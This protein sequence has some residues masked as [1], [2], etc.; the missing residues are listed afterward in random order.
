MPAECG[1]LEPMDKNTFLQLVIAQ[2]NGLHS[3][4]L[5]ELGSD[6]AVSFTLGQAVA[7]AKQSAGVTDTPQ[8]LPL[9]AIDHR[10]IIEDAL[11][12]T[13]FNAPPAFEEDA[14]ENVITVHPV[15]NE[16]HLEQVETEG[17]VSEDEV[18]QALASVRTSFATLH[19]PPVD[20]VLPED[21]EEED[22]IPQVGVYAEIPTEDGGTIK[23]GDADQFR[24][25]QEL[26][27]GEPEGEPQVVITYRRLDGQEFTAEQLDRV[28]NSDIARNGRNI[29]GA[30]VRWGIDP[31]EG[32]PSAY[33]TTWF[34][35]E[36]DVPLAALRASCVQ[37]RG[38]H[39][40]PGV[41][42]VEAFATPFEDVQ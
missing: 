40:F 29:L 21:A 17:D 2:L 7:A 38:S 1:T 24:Q 20:V 34:V 15:L 16:G 37:Y 39:P 18:E 42:L 41:G 23:V 3:T 8:N 31:V 26:F 19:N 22:V 28:M 14:V 35:A 9:D 6:H 13:R 32:D 30:R 36:G 10:Q 4:A 27:E 5:S 12:I 25:M 33:R 11:P